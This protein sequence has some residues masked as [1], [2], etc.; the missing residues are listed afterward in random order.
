MTVTHTLTTSVD[1]IDS[2]GFAIAE[3][4]VDITF[5]VHGGSRAT[6]TDPEY[7]AE[8]EVL[9]VTHG[10]KDAPGWAWDIV[11]NNGAIRDAMWEVVAADRDDAAEWRAQCRR[12][13]AMMTGWAS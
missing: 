3:L 9:T 6:C 4:D 2:A 13:D 7:G 11:Q 1:Q 8:L 10:G 5:C 12:D